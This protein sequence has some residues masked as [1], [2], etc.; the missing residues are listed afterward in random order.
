ME[1]VVKLNSRYHINNTLTEIDEH[2]WVLK[3]SE[4]DH[5]RLGIDNKDNTKYVF[6][7]PPGGPFMSI[8]HVIDEINEIIVSI[9]FVE[10]TGFVITTK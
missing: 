4:G 10:G 2:K 6:I 1:K 5:I 3:S 7:D 8:N 9:D